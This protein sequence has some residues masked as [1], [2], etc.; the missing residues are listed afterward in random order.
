[1]F[2]TQDKIG[3][4]KPNDV[5]NPLNNLMSYIQGT[6]GLKNQDASDV[7]EAGAKAT[8]YK[9]SVSASDMGRE[10]DKEK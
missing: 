9:A 3:N 10:Y 7:I 2:L 1:M 5:R 4:M 6:Q 8:A